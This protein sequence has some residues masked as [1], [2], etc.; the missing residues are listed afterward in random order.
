MNGSGNHSRQEIEQYLLNA[1]LQDPSRLQTL[2]AS[3][4]KADDFLVYR[5]VYNLFET[6]TKLYASVPSLDEI[7]NLQPDWRETV[8]AFDYW[9]DTFTNAVGIQRAQLAIYDTVQR[10]QGDVNNVEQYVGELAQRLGSV[11]P[12]RFTTLRPT[13]AAITDRL[14]RFHKRQEILSAHPDT[15][16]GIRSGLSLIDESHMGWL[17]GD[18]V[19]IL[20]R[21]GVG[22]TW[23]L[24]WQGV[25]A[26]LQ[27]KRILLISTEMPES[28]ISMRMDTMIAGHIGIPI[29]ERLL[30]AGHPSQE[31]A[32]TELS[33]SIA[34][35]GRWYTE[36]GSTLSG[37][38]G[39][40]DIRRRVF[41]FQPD[42]ILVDGIGLLR[43]EGK[44]VQG[45]EQ[46]KALS[47]DM[48]NYATAESLTILV[49]HQVV[50]N[51]GGGGKTRGSEFIMPSLSDVAFGDAL[52]HACSTIIMMVADR[53]NP[54]LRWYSIKKN[55]NGELDYISRLALG[56]LVDRGVIS[57]L[58]NHRDDLDAISL[59]LRKL[60]QD[61]LV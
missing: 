16:F 10:M 30:K 13:D 55:R 27:G 25:K 12:R 45:W 5:D 32:Y 4:L 51:P 47:Y 26:W 44:S 22:K 53:E 18:M 49:T 14:E 24:I 21:S 50:R 58:G 23:F 54:Y 9:L 36:D 48:K 17:P 34:N 33:T 29:S 7:K 37:S 15:V 11:I 59:G 2:V 31:A 61:G 8:G 38:I 43:Y 46:L 39:L 19:G 20:A 35:V 52:V 28:Q 40:S 3:G 57:D 60:E 56:W 42:V 6:H 1:L 41:E